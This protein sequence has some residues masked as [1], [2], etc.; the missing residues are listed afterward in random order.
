M[1]GTKLLHCGQ[2]R[3]LAVDCIRFV[4]L[5]EV[6]ASITRLY[7][8][9]VVIYMLLTSFPTEAHPDLRNDL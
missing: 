6:K 2:A 1:V 4:V 5:C 8:C 7:I 3:V 9:H